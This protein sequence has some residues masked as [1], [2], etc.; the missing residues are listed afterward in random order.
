MHPSQVSIINLPN[1]TE[2]QMHL[3]EFHSQYGLQYIWG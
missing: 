2:V 3:R 1:K